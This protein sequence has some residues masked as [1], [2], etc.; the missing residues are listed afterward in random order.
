MVR[1]VDK[2]AEW[3]LDKIRKSKRV[4][5]EKLGMSK[6]EYD[7]QAEKIIERIRNNTYS[8]L[9]DYEDRDDVRAG[10]ASQLILQGLLI[11]ETCLNKNA[12]NKLVVAMAN[13]MVSDGPMWPKENFFVKDENGNWLRD[14]R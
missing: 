9:D 3:M 8:I 10:I 14:T 13:Q 1:K 2:D 6:K 4:I 5:E 12:L 7:S 11:G